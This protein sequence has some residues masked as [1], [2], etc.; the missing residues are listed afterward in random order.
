[1]GKCGFR[2]EC[3]ARLG[4]QI[5]S[6]VFPTITETFD[7]LP[8]G[9]VIGSKILVVHGGIGD[10]EWNIEQLRQVQRPI[11]HDKL[12]ATPTLYNILWSDPIAEDVE[13]CY[14]VHDSPRDGHAS[15]IRS[16]GPDVTER[17]CRRNGLDMVVRSHQVLNK[18]RGYEVMHHSKCVR[19]FSARD[20]EGCENDGSILSIESSGSGPLVVRPQVIRSIKCESPNSKSR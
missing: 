9:C 15:V 8:F 4:G 6:R 13:D 19:V 17:F 16:F 12:F 1:M 3:Q 7:M 10:G 11:D 20:Y 5:G 18:G 2:S 14:G